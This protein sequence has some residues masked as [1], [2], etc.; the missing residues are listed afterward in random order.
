MSREQSPVDLLVEAYQ[1]AK[2]DVVDAVRKV[3]AE[4]VNRPADPHAAKLAGP[5]RD[6]EYQA[7]MSDPARFE[8]MALQAADR[9]RVPPGMVPRRFVDWLREGYKREKKQ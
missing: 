1:A 2:T 9:F 7:A 4:T 6:A 8:S 5:E 3:R